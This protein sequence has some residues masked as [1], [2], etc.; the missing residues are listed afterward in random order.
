LQDF[1]VHNLIGVEPPDWKLLQPP[2][3]ATPAG[4]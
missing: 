4:N 2:A 1:F 3:T